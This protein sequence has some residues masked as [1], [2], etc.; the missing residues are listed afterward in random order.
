MVAWNVWL[1]AIVLISSIGLSVATSLSYALGPSAAWM[2][3]SKVFIAL[4]SFLVVS[5]LASI[6]IHSLAIGK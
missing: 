5:L 2:A 1:F 3:G 6:A 4:L